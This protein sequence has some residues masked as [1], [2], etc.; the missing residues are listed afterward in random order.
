MEIKILYKKYPKNLIHGINRINFSK[1]IIFDLCVGDVSEILGELEF[2]ADVWF[3]DGFSPSKNPEMWSDEIILKIANLSKIGTKI[4]TYSS[5]RSVATS[6]EK[7][8]F[9]AWKVQGFGKKRE[10]I[11]A[12]KI[13]NNEFIKNSHFSRPKTSINLP[14]KRSVLIVGAGIAGLA[15][16]TK[17]KKLG[18]R[19]KIAEKQGKVATNGSSN[20]CGVAEPLITQNGVKL[21]IMHI[22][23]FLQAYQFYK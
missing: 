15:T 2:D 9:E 3:L 13:K 22:C 14:K 12:K 7:N 4:A 1:N 16:A 21:G 19:V 10:M 5:A 11:R 6:L 17:L 8:G 20:F 18:F 23:A